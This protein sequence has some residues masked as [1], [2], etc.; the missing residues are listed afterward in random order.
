MKSIKSKMF[1]GL[2]LFTAA[3]LS[4]SCRKEK[5]KMIPPEISF[6]TGSGYT[7]A[8][9]TV[10]MNDTLTVGINAKKTEDKDLL[11]R[12]VVTQ[13]YDAAAATTIYSESFNQDTYSK[14]LTIITRNVAGT[15]KYTYTIIN[16]DGL[17]NTVSLL[18]TVN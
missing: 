1:Y 3:T 9:A 7:S 4:T 6:K 15:E 16:R 18:L 2:L 13:Q 17:T 10:G 12:F 11:Q 8:N 14:D 5:D